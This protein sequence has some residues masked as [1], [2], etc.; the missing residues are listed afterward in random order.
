MTRVEW[1]LIRKLLGKPRRCSPAF[2]QEE[3]DTLESK[4]QKVRILQRGGSIPSDQLHDLPQSIPALLPV[5]TRVTC[6]VGKRANTA[7]QFGGRQISENLLCQG[8]V[9]VVVK[10][11]SDLTA[12]LW[13]PDS[14][15]NLIFRNITDI[16]FVS[17][18]NKLIL[19]Q[20]CLSQTIV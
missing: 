9:E 13:C 20:Q 16:A 7:P 2:F 18:T 8:V 4:R 5:G 17:I 10:V 6:R 14:G 12:H 11:C 15:P 3:R 19:A 1:N